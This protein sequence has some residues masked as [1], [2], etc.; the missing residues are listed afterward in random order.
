MKTILELSSMI[1][2]T[3]I[4]SFKLHSMIYLLKRKR[5]EFFSCGGKVSKELVVH[6]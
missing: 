4:L 2:E 1:L 6:A 3:A 5:P